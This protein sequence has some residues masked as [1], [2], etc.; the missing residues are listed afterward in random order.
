VEAVGEGNRGQDL[1]GDG[2]VGGLSRREILKFAVAGGGGLL[3]GGIA[4][5]RV[6]GATSARPSARQD[7]AVLNYALLLE[8]L[9][10]A[11]YEDALARLRLR[12]ELREFAEVVSGHEKAHVA[13]LEKALGPNARQK[14]S[15]DFGQATSRPKKFAAVARVL[16]DAGVAAYN[17]QAANLT[18]PTLAAAVRIVSVEGRHAAWIRDLVGME[19][20]PR[21]ADPGAS[22]GEVTARLKSLKF[23]R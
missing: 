21:A 22:V 18:K 4:V 3:L 5:E 16:E 17:G 12:G 8:Y 19:P 9:Q 1:S 11:F 2:R 15:F 14:P 20:A 13:F 7:R 6:L 10:A 23:V